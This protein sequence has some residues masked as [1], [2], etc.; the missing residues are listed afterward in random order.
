MSC[1]A[2]KSRLGHKASRQENALNYLTRRQVL[3]I[4]LAGLSFKFAR[5]ADTD[6][7]RMI[8]RSP[9]PTDFEMPLDGFTESITPIQRFFVRC[10]TN[11][12]TVN[13]KTWKLEL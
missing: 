7:S 3:G 4:A 9:F 5:A 12:P 2:A 6:L 10:H 8:V 1:D 13:L 11:V